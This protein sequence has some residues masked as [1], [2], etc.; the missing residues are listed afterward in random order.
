MADK[1]FGIS[2]AVPSQIDPTIPPEGQ[3]TTADVRA[4]FATAAQEITDLQAAAEGAPFLPLAGGQ[5]GG[6]LILYNDPGSARE[7]ATKQ[8]VEQKLAL[9]LPGPKGD[10]GP[11]GPPGPVGPAGVPGAQGPAGPVGQG[12]Q[13][14][15]GPAGPTGATGAQGDTGPYGI[16]GSQGDP[17]PPGPWGPQGPA[18]ATGATGA[19]GAPGPQGPNWQVGTGLALNTGTTPSTVLFANVADATMLAN[20]SGVPA[21]AVPTTLTALLDKVFGTARATI[22]YRGATAWAALPPGPNG[23]HLM[24]QGPNADPLWVTNATLQLTPPDPTGTTSTAGVMCGFGIA[25]SVITPAATG[26]ILISVTGAAGVTSGN[27]PGTVKLVVGIG[28][29]PANG[30]ALPAGATVISSTLAAAVRAE[31]ELTG[32]T[33]GLTR[34]TQ[35]WIDVLQASPVSN[36]TLSLTNNTITAVGMG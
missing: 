30:A 15:P 20:I 17:G 8:F 21:P 19:Q 35:Y 27:T 11:P 32:L 10:P 23:S 7:A 18:G 26:N 16:Q 25:G 28:T 13:G 9:G 14:P 3:P 6:P 4:N 24:S 2:R 22:L 31:F 5:L 1:P 33:L 12:T 29:P 36:Q 34:G